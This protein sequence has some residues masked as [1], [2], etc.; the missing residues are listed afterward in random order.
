M[1]KFLTKQQAT[2]EALDLLKL[3]LDERLDS[4]RQAHSEREN[5]N[6]HLEAAF[7]EIEDFYN[8]APVG[9]HST[10]EKGIVVR[11]NDTELRWLGYERSEVIGKMPIGAFHTEGDLV[12]KAFEE[13]KKTG[14]VHNELFRM[15]RKDGSTFDVLLSA[16]AI[17]DENGQY[18]MSRTVLTDVTERK[19]LTDELRRVNAELYHLNEEKNRFVGITSHDLQNPLS[20][21]SMS[22]EML[23]KT[24]GNLTEM[25]RKLVKNIRTTAD[26]MAILVKNILNLNRIERGVTQPDFQTVNVKSLAWDVVNRFLIFAEKKKI[27]LHFNAPDGVDFTLSSDAN[28]VVQI[29]EN[30]I[31]NALKFSDKEKN[32]FVS[33]SKSATYV[34]IK[35]CDEGQGIKTEEVGLLFGRFQK[36]SARPTGG[37]SSTGLGLSIVKEYVELLRGTLDVESTWGVGSTFTLQLPF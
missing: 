12:E 26:R 6:A 18:K 20:A 1:S 9:Y 5:P 3:P 2:A 25:Q 16:T 32:V 33:L 31:S 4:I 17:Y 15:R 36:L 37:E 13:F 35:I 11:M 8:N 19:V 27:N 21:I 28:F 7:R 23:Q 24:G 30:L 14:F 34:E 10:D 29:L 22:A